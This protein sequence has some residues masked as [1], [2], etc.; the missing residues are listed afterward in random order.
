[1]NRSKNFILVLIFAFLSLI[2][3]QLN[4]RELGSVA[5][6]IKQYKLNWDINGSNCFYISNQTGALNCLPPINGYQTVSEINLYSIATF[7]DKGEPDFIEELYFPNMT[8]FSFDNSAAEIETNSSYS[9]LALLDNRNNLK[10]KNL[11]LTGVNITM[12]VNFPSNLPITTLSLV[13]CN[14]YSDMIMNSLFASQLQNIFISF[15]DFPKYNK[16][17][18]DTFGSFNSPVKTLTIRTT[19]VQVV[20]GLIN[21]TDSYFP[22]LSSLEFDLSGTD[23]IEL[24]LSKLQHIAIRSALITLGNL[25]SLVYLEMWSGSSSVSDYTVFPLLKD[26]I[27]YSIS[28]PVT[29]AFNLTKLVAHNTPVPIVPDHTWLEKDYSEFQLYNTNSSG[30][31][32]DINLYFP[33]TSSYFRLNGMQNITG[34]LYESFCFMSVFDFSGIT[35]TNFTIPDCFKCYQSEIVSLLPKNIPQ[36]PLDFVCNVTLDSYGY[37]INEWLAFPI[38]GNNLGF[39]KSSAPNMLSKQISNK[40]FGLSVASLSGKTTISFSTV[41]NYSCDIFWGPTLQVNYIQTDNSKVGDLL[42][43]LFGMFNSYAPLSVNIGGNICNITLIA[44]NVVNCA[45]T[46]YTTSVPL[47]TSTTDTVSS[48]NLYSSPSFTM[49]K[50]FVKERTFILYA[51]F[52]PNPYNVTV[53]VSNIYKSNISF[54]NE[55]T[56][57]S[58]LPS[59]VIPFKY[60]SFYISANGYNRVL[61]MFVEGDNDC[62][63]GSTCNGN[64]NCTNGKCRCNDGYGGYY[65]QAPLSPGVVILPNNTIPSPTII[66]KDG[67]NF[68]FNIIAIQEIDELSSVVRELKTDKWSYSTTGNETF[69]ITTY[70]LQSTTAGI[71]QINATIEYSKNSRL[72]NFAGQSTLYP[73][74]SLKLMITINNWSFK[75]RLNQLRVL[76]ESSSSIVKEDEC[77]P[78][79]DITVNNGSDVSYLQ[80][81]IGDRSFYVQN[82]V[83]NQT[84]DS[85]LIGMTLPYCDSCVIDPDFSVLINNVGNNEHSCGDKKFASWK[86]ATIIVVLSVVAVSAAVTT[87]YQTNW[88]LAATTCKGIVNGD[89]ASSINCLQKN[90]NYDSVISLVVF[91]GINRDNGDPGYIDKLYFPYISTINFQANYTERNPSYS[92]L[93]LLLNDN[94]PL[95][96][97]ISLTNSNINLTSNSFSTAP[98]L[99]SILISSSIMHSDFSFASMTQLYNINLNNITFTSNFKF[100]FDLPGKTFPV[101]NSLYLYNLN[102]VDTFGQ[103]RFLKSSFPQLKIISIFFNKRENVYLESDATT[104]LTIKV[105]NL[106]LGDCPILSSIS[107]IDCYTTTNDFT[108]FPNLSTLYILQTYVPSPPDQSWVNDKYDLSNPKIRTLSSTRTSGHL[109]DFY[110]TALGSSLG[111]LGNQNVSV[112]LYESYCGIDLIGLAATTLTDFNVADCFYCY[113]SQMTNKLPL[114]TPAPNNFICNITIE[115]SGYHIIKSTVDSSYY[116]VINGRNLGWGNG[117][118]PSLTKLLSNKKF[119]YTI[120]QNQ[121]FG[122]DQIIFENTYNKKFDIFWGLPLNI[123]Y[124]QTENIASND[125]LVKLFGVF[126]TYAPLNVS[127]GSQ[128][129]QITFNTTGQLNCIISN[130]STSESLLVNTTDTISSVGL[131]SSPGLFIVSTSISNEILKVQANFG[132]NPYNVSILISNQYKCDIS[133]LGDSQLACSPEIGLFPYTNY[134][135]TIFANGYNQTKNFY[136]TADDCSTNSA[137]NGNGNCTNGKCRCNDGYGG[138]Y[139]QA[140]L[141]PGVVILPNNTDPSPTIIVK[142]G[143]NFTFNIIAIQ[144]IDELSSVVR[145][146]KTDKWSYSTTGNETFS[147]TTYSLQSTTA[148][149]DQINTTIEYSNSSRL[150]NFAG[151]STL[152]PENSLK[153][154][155]TINNWSFKD[156]LNQLRVLMESSS[157]ITKDD[158]SPDLDITVSNGSDVSYLQMTIGDRSFY[159]NQTKDSI[160]IGMTLP[161]CDSCVID[162]DFSV[163][164][165]NDD[166]TTGCKNEKFASWKIATI[167]VVLSAVV[168]SVGVATIFFMKK[169]LKNQRENQQLYV[170]AFE[171]Q[172]TIY[173]QHDQCKLHSTP[174]H[175]YFQSSLAV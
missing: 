99:N 46:N 172:A 73:E 139:C 125:L 76:M 23:K 161:Y 163:L 35:L 135:L 65:C 158:C 1:M 138:Y 111:I 106:T 141:S 57:T 66:V 144:E 109:G 133:T 114:N 167:V 15:L 162:P 128:N 173:I 175:L 32:E 81:T 39:G 45:I 31:L 40:K 43:Q 113:W 123:S 30:E 33:S 164:I 2:N 34:S 67:M 118:S 18:L 112:S 48:I 153:L 75:D 142:D 20:G 160:L 134:S 70:S 52:G 169:R 101:L 94:K 19:Q 149:I 12:P 49:L 53:Y 148:G 95:L 146:L 155:I 86:I 21:L 63:T 71:D 72:I 85:I 136:Y 88:D 145:E 44:S 166:G 4:Q 89:T 55:T 124:I 29:K 24:H 168:V 62:G 47:L 50:A 14:V 5:F 26:L 92:T 3:A 143:M 137:C 74:N 107:L 6:L 102:S 80:M 96:T 51:N 58:I 36:V 54:I 82:R 131:Y 61:T 83:I 90:G 97:T 157:S 130:Y 110:K 156:R 147:I 77:S 115:S 140:P 116:F 22:N 108:V 25:P 41:K 103:A 119:K 11:Y 13:G 42:V 105:V 132:V 98:N 150:I 121:F 56:M 60:Y 59:E 87:V 127:V 17:I 151:Q 165:A 38:T 28:S 126:N 91:N 122:R 104:Y 93:Q 170:V 79:L 100:L 69:S 9:L 154:I 171:M 129:C 7:T 152:Y 78:D 84:K 37:Y 174:F 120:P 27:M 64:G 8:L 68:T 117:M 16:L 10:L 159:V